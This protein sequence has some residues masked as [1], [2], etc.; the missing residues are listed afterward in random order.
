M[1]PWEV[2]LDKYP[3]FRFFNNPSEQWKVMPSFLAGELLFYAITVGALIHAARSFKITGSYNNLIIF[4]AALVAG[5]ANDVFFMALPFANNFWQAQAM[6]MLTPRLPLYIPCV[7]IAFMYYPTVSAR[8]FVIE[9]RKNFPA[10]SITPQTSFI[11]RFFKTLFTF[12]R[13]A[14]GIVSGIMAMLFYYPYDVTGAKFLWWTWHDTDAPI[15]Q[16][17]NGAPASSTLWT[18]TFVAIFSVLVDYR[19]D[20]GSGNES[21]SSSNGSRKS[22]PTASTPNDVSTFSLTTFISK[23]VTVLWPVALFSTPVMMME[24]G[25]FQIFEPQGCPGYIALAIACT[26]FFIAEKFT[27]YH[28]SETNDDAFQK[29]MSKNHYQ[30]YGNNVFFMTN[31]VAYCVGLVIISLVFSPETHV[32]RGAHQLTGKCGVEAIDITGNK[33]E[34]YLCVSNFNEPYDFHCVEPKSLIPQK[35]EQVEWYTVCGTPHA[36]WL[37]F[38][39]AIVWRVVLVVYSL[40]KAV[41]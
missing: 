14:I 30:R 5:T 9:R 20:I 29:E 1:L 8:L 7:Y 16:R 18:L 39:W 26:V 17:I 38:V 41:L 24:M 34:L 10:P 32:S 4:V 13:L 11:V 37:W 28:Q 33:R 21:V 6:I 22:A 3:E 19:L 15:V 2:S 25:V 23:L 36:S 12:Q 35:D 40:G 27:L 31:V